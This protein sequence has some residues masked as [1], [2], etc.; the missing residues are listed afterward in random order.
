M[1]IFSYTQVSHA[2]PDFIGYGYSSCI[3][4][5]FNGLGSG[6]LNDYGRALFAQEITARDVF[7][8]SMEDEEIAAMSGF[9]GSK[10]LPWWIRPGIKYR[11]LWLQQG[12]G[13]D[14]R[15]ERF[16]N[17]QA[18]VNLN[19]IL[20]KK[21]DY[22]AVLTPSYTALEP[23]YGKQNTWFMKE[24]Y[25]RVK[26]TNNYWLYLGQMDK[27]YGVRQIDHSAYS[28]SG[29][30]LDQYS[31]STGAILHITYSDWD[32]ALNGFV[33]NAAQE[34]PDKQKGFS[35]TGEYQV[36]EKFK[37][38]ASVLSSESDVRKYNLAGVQ[39]RMGLTK[40]SSLIAEAGLKE[41]TT[42][43]TA[44]KQLGS[45]AYVQTLINFRRG[46]NLL[47]TIEQSRA[48]I[49]KSSTEM[50]KWSFGALLFPVPRS[51]LRLM[52][53]NGKAYDET[54]AIQDSWAFQAQYH[55]SY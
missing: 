3:T 51:E 46:Y 2:Y 33:G 47:S 27:A 15:M 32:V 24:Y 41:I 49:E 36:Y 14:Q 21:Q 52:F 40:G 35:A 22:V 44:I 17:M 48:D 9:L 55:L 18:D 6:A 29:L 5:H 12:L 11:G 26:I 34:D 30:G 16:I 4:C 28:R 31:Q 53:V 8:K 7:P 20:N 23:Y 37:V 38:G 45:Y 1:S 39:T 42:K 54:V 43:A 19:F 13:T 10:P 25:L 50:M